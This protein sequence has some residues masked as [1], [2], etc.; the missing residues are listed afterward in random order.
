MTPMT[1]NNV[2]IILISFS[3]LIFIFLE[4]LSLI[5]CP[6]VLESNLLTEINQPSVQLPDAQSCK[7]LLS[8][9]VTELK[10]K[11]ERKNQG[12]VAGFSQNLER[13]LI[14]YNG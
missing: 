5:A 1:D 12:T 4:Y 3:A 7:T 9:I 6:V 11:N 13:R 14:D 2:Y 8:S 10:K